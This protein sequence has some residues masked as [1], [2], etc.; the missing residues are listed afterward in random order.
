MDDLRRM[1]IFY[2][3]VDTQSFS[4]AARKLGIAR[5][6]VSRHITLLEKSIG[7]R[8][9][10]RTTRSLSLTEVGHSYFKS[11]A[12][13]VAEAELATQQISE[14]QEEPIGTLKIAGPVSLGM[15]LI[16]PLVREFMKR[17]RELN[18]ELVLE[19][20][21]VDMVKEG[22]DISIRVGWLQDSNLVAKKLGEWPR[23]LCASPEYIKRMGK[24]KNPAELVDYEWII[25]SLL[26]TPYHCVFKKD[27][28]EQRIQ[29]K[30]RLKTN[31]ANAVRSCLLGGSGIAVMLEFLVED[32]I[33][34]G[35]LQRLLP[36]YDCGSI[37]LYAVYQDRHYQQ[38]KVRLF[39]E[40]IDNQLKYII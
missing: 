38:A 29:V 1:S 13:I 12:R 39:I 11:C 33:K 2:H 16:A 35:R 24:P 25:L 30:G 5:S 4:S 36:D 37:G 3:V 17:Y 27:N 8:L 23:L 9:L 10:N 21:V 19:D 40:F 32:D 15:E 18:V 6:A 20:N 22:I 14:L 28:H 34:A 7:V 31:N 26:P